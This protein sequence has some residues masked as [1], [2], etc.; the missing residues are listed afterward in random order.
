M[1]VIHQL[2][3]QKKAGRPKVPIDKARSPGISV[4]LTP[5][6]RKPIDA[7]IKA[8]GLTQS[9]WARKSLLYIAEHGICIT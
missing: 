1:F 7:A 4:R 2:S 6:E 3:M 5:E 9:N 8:S